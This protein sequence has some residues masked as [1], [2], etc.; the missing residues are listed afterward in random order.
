MDECKPLP[1]RSRHAS[2]LVVVLALLSASRSSVPN[3]PFPP[4]SASSNVHDALDQGL[5]QVLF[6][7]Q[8]QHTR[9]FFSGRLNPRI[10]TL[11]LE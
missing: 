5:T 3:P 1:L 11:P 7:R 2:K 9:T 4:L 10:P 6:R 8:N